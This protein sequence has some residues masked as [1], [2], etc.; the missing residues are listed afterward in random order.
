[1]STA[2]P[3]ETTTEQPP[4]EKTMSGTSRIKN[5]QITVIGVGGA[6]GNVVNN[7]IA[8]GSATSNS[9]LP[10]PTCRRSLPPRRSTAFSL[11]RT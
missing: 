8:A 4:T 2:T 1:M 3:A 7:M 9:W 5:P 6:G 11:A 10:T